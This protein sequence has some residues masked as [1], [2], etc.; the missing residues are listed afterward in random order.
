MPMKKVAEKAEK[1]VEKKAVAKVEKRDAS[2]KKEM[3][4]ELPVK[5]K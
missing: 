1:M 2:V 3:K 4:K 5:K